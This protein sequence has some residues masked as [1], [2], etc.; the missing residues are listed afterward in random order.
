[1]MSTNKY[2]YLMGTGALI[3]AGIALWWLSKDHE[4]AIFDEKVHTVEKLRQMVHEMFLEGAT[5][6]CSKRNAIR[7]KKKELD[8]IIADKNETLEKK[9]EAEKFNWEFFFDE[10]AAKSATEIEEAEKYLYDEKKV[11]E[12]M[13]QHWFEKYAG[14]KEVEAVLT[15]LKKI[16][17]DVF[18]KKGS[19][20][21]HIICKNKPNGMDEDSY[22]LVFRKT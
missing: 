7:T 19:T 20:I 3:A 5:I 18:C 2:S 13:V 11:S 9:T 22:I 10:L 1:M 16:S 14:D 15:N 12:E 21:Q 4:E 17:D 6:Y 8:E